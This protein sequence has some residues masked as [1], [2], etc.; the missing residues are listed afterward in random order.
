MFFSKTQDF[1]L[2]HIFPRSE[3]VSNKLEDGFFLGFIK[4]ERAVGFL[5]FSCFRTDFRRV[6][7][8]NAKYL[9]DN[10]IAQSNAAIGTNKIEKKQDL[11]V[12]RIQAVPLG[13]KQDGRDILA[14]QSGLLKCMLNEF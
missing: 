14:R 12:S 1:S 11:F 10:L 8:R 3:S 7:G 6:V 4:F 9:R 13:C 2:G 5:R